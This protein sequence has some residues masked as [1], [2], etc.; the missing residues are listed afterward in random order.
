[1]HITGFLGEVFESVAVESLEAG[2]GTG[3]YSGMSSPHR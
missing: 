2:A 3:L 1:L